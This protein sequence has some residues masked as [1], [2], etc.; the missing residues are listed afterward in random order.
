MPQIFEAGSKFN[1]ATTMNANQYVTIV[2]FPLPDRVMAEAKDTT[3]QT[4]LELSCH[5]MTTLELEFVAR[6]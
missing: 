6:Y 1:T 5:F 2:Y 4:L 3:E